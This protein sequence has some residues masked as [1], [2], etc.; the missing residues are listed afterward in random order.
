MQS[1]M[2]A[3]QIHEYGGSDILKCQKVDMPTLASSEVMVKIEAAGVNFID[4]YQRTGLYPNPRGF[5]WRLG[6]EGAG[7]VTEVGSDVTDIQCG[8][9]VA[10]TGVQGTYAEYINV[11][12]TKALK[13]PP[14][15]DSKN[16]AAL[17]IQGLTAHYLL[18]SIRPVKAEDTILIQAGAG[19]TGGLLIQMAKIIGAKV[20]TTVS[21]EAKAA[22]A[23]GH[24]ADHVIVY[25][26]QDFVAEVA[27]ITKGD[28]CAV[29]LDGVG[30][31]TWERSLQ[32]VSRCGHLILFGNASGAVPPINPLALAGAGSVSLT[33]PRLGDYVVGE[34]LRKR[35][36]D[37]LRWMA[38]GKLKICI[39]N[40]YP[41]KDAAKAHDDLENRRTTGKL[42]L[43][44]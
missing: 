1:A 24:G 34:W 20:I 35:A 39:G 31:S 15:I 9:K 37:I 8:D 18:H 41:L 25:T 42:L 2:H 19:G 36:N 6:R 44:P 28:K 38:E 32:C 5:P 13:L 12:A 30:K 23:R 26:E 4:T 29:V 43:I 16:G 33:R 40:T 14:G 17:V 27:R 11:P 10:F 3:I 7:V 22:V 21:T